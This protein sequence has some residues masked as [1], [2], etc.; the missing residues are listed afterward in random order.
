MPCPIFQPPPSSSRVLSRIATP[1]ARGRLPV[2]GVPV[3]GLPVAG[4]P[5]LCS[6]L[7]RERLVHLV[8]K[9]LREGAKEKGDDDDDD[10][11]S[12]GMHLIRRNHMVEVKEA[13]YEPHILSDD[14]SCCSARIRPGASMS[15][16]ILARSSIWVFFRALVGQNAT[17]KQALWPQACGQVVKMP[18]IYLHG[19]RWLTAGTKG[20]VEIR[21]R[22]LEM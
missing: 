13:Y 10:S 12:S 22:Y 2:D 19:Q 21:K 8:R 11:S 1:S 14:S 9:L 18:I 3:A 5:R 20:G 15:S 6:H 7:R 4:I 17:Q 16:G